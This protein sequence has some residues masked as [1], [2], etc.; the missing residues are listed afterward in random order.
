MLH[1]L[2]SLRDVH[3]LGLHAGHLNHNFR[4]QEAEDDAVFAADLAYNLGVPVTVVKEDPHEYQKE[5]GISSFEQGAREMRY[6]FLARIAK[7]AGASAVT[8]G[9]TSDDLAETV[10][11]H[12]LRGSGLHG[13]R[14]MTVLSNWPWPQA[15]PGLVIFRPLLGVTK[16]QTAVYVR[17]KG[18]TYREDSGNY[19]WRFTR[20]RV[21]HD[22]MP[23]LAKDYNPQV[24]KA[25]V[26][27]AQ[28]A[29]EELDFV[30]QELDQAWPDVAAESVG[31]VRFS[32]IAL[33]S[34][35]PLLQR[36]ALRRGY[37]SVSGDPTRLGESHLVSMI[38]L[39]GGE[40]GGRTLEL[41]GGVRLRREYE[42]LVLTRNQGPDCPYPDF[43]GEHT[44]S[45]PADAVIDIVE[46]VGPWYL[47][48]R[49]GLAGEAPPWAAPGPDSNDLPDLTACLDRKSLEGG[50]TVRTWRPG[51]RIQPSGM[52][53]Q[54]KLQDLFTD[55]RVP[56]HWRNRIPI[57]ESDRGIAWVVGH[58]IADWAKVNNS[59][60]PQ[61][62]IWVKFSLRRD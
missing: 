18:Q 47:A 16:E 44:I 4:G 55:L 56:R 5:R 60:E 36:L 10:M 34:L 50:V 42:E 54:K 33:G 32:R 17:E 11:L 21:R 62:V 2:V 24:R 61:P 48:V 52:Q 22:L 12:V 38:N 31:E 53:G 37:I 9:H 46:S 45:Q 29:A 1:A 8:V 57:L 28:T 43:G 35:H 59:D 27:L 23:K 39:V 51:D 13:L 25:L 49:S 40:R 41:P 15:A 7:E 14:G 26:R 3:G 6:T 19:M 30:E 20:N 58:R